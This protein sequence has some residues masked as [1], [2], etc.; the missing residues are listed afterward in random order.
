L[1][2][3]KEYYYGSEAAADG[4]SLAAWRL[5]CSP[6]AHNKGFLFIIIFKRKENRQG[7]I[8]PKNFFK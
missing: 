7:I 8:E 5:P 4:S 6:G 3:T 1:P 2:A